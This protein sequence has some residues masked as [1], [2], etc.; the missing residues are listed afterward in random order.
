MAPP[1]SVESSGHAAVLAPAPWDVPGVGGARVT[2][3]RTF[4]SAPQGCPYVITR[5]E[6]DQPGLYGLGCASDPQRTL[7]IRSVVDDY[8][9]PMLLGRDPADIE[10]LHRLLLHSGYWRGGSIANNALASIDVALWDIKGKMAGLP[11]YQLLGGRAREYAEAYTHVDGVDVDEVADLVLAARER[12]YRHV[13]VQL[14]VPGTD[15]YGT[16]PT[17]E[18]QAER[19]RLRRESWDSLAYLRHVPAALVGV[20]D[21][22]GPDVELLHDAHERLTPAQARQFVRAVEDARLYFLEDALA[23]EDAAHFPGLRAAGST[24]IAV[25]ELYA[26]VAQYLPLLE[27]RVIDYARI[28]IP[29]LGGLTPTRKLVAAC[30]LFGVRTAPHGPGDVSPVGQAANVALDISSPAFGVQEA[31]TFRDATLEVFPGAPVPVAGRF[32][33]GPAPGLGV[34]FDETAARRH[35]VTAPL[36]HDRWALLRATDGSAH[37]P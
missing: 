20:R 21:R 26:D 1:P 11:L 18:R 14:A 17:D 32:H 37:R 9:G 27:Q 30:E 4:L 3:V 13:R 19:R 12:G 25:G 2:R 10:D 34:D 31:A 7:A 15:T 33:P 6:T 35:P 28:R 24:P 22:V 5:V 16:A 8:L 29:T 23:P 36:D